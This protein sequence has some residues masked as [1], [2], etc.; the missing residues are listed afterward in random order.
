MPKMVMN[1]IIFSDRIVKN[2][3][4]IFGMS[5]R[6]AKNFFASFLSVKS[7]ATYT[8]FERQG[9]TTFIIVW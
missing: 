8:F 7:N 5:L 4:K 3:Q 6:E 2:G 9:I 1:E